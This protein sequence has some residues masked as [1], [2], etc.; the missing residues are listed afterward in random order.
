MSAEDFSYFLLREAGLLLPSSATATAA[1]ATCGH[2]IGPCMLH[3]P[4]YD[5]ND[6]LIPLGA[7]CWVQLAEQWLTRRAP[8]AAA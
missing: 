5:F 8:Q 2:G 3:N 6:D 4:S 1:T 7:T